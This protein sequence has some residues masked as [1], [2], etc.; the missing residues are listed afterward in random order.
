MIKQKHIDASREARLWITQ[1]IIPVGIGSVIFAKS[2]TGKKTI[3]WTK[4][5]IEEFKSKFRKEN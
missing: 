1:V 2:E 5:K 3:A 4:N